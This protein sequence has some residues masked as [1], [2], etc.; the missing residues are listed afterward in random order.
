[1]QSKK[2]LVKKLGQ[3]ISEVDW[4]KKKQPEAFNR[5]RKESPQRQKKPRLTDLNV[6]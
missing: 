6:L 4:I 3:F 5:E 2:E 1:M